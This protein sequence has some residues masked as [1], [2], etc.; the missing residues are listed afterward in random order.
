VS[1]PKV[2]VMM[3]VYNAE[4]YLRQ[5]IESILGQT[6]DDFEL[7]IIDDGST[8]SS[9]A[10]IRSYSDARIRVLRNESNSGVAYSRKRALLNARGHFVAVLDADDVS[11][12]RR[13]EIQV[14]FLDTHLDVVV[15]C[16]GREVVDENGKV[17]QV[18]RGVL[19]H[20]SMHW[21]LL[22]GNPIANSS[23]MFR[24]VM[25]LEVGGYDE[26]RLYGPEDYDLWSRLANRGKIAQL[27]NPLVQYREHSDSLVHTEPY[28]GRIEIALE[29]VRDNIRSIT[30][31]D[32]PID[33]ARY[34]SEYPA[35]DAFD[36]ATIELAYDTLFLCLGN[37]VQ[38]KAKTKADVFLTVSLALDDLERISRRSPKSR[39]RSLNMALGLVL[40][41]SP[42]VIFTRKF[43]RFA[44]RMSVP[45]AMR[46]R[47]QPHYPECL[48][49]DKSPEM[50]SHEKHS[51]IKNGVKVML[52]WIFS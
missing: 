3:A 44:W 29:I 20:L 24:R 25:A 40:Q 22:F 5:A 50:N 23:T 46:K 28:M 26:K 15:V 43:I 47:L 7:L 27:D 52:I 48:K 18:N 33:V 1:D 16:S 41:H 35:I 2:T 36:P 21:R 37:M 14:A 39:W 17:L 51:G 49:T 13:L 6:F 9:P 8:D 10:I 11:F 45:E 31:I 19:D 42:D 30:G 34:L 38:M 12:P 4:R 32:V